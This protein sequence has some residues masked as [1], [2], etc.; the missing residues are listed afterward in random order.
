MPFFSLAM[1]PVFV[2][3]VLSFGLL[4]VGVIN[5]TFTGNLEP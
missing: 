2:A 5:T 3:G 4:F 1:V